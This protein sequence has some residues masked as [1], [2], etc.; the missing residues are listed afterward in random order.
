MCEDDFVKILK[1]YIDS[2]SNVNNLPKT[3]N[4]SYTNKYKLSE[5]AEMILKDK[6][7]IDIQDGSCSNNYCGCGTL[8]DNMC[9]GLDGL[10]KSLEKYDARLFL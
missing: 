2:S 1:Y 8:L 7:K 3:I 10:E 9:L 5:I 4:L 6:S